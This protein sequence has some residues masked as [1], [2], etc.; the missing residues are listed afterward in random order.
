MGHRK[1]FDT[2]E[3]II[4][5]VETFQ[6]YDFYMYKERIMKAEH[7]WNLLWLKVPSIYM[8]GCYG[9]IEAKLDP[10][11]HFITPGQMYLS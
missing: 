8:Y 6:D 1:V 11:S 10:M 3:D 2:D 9:I 5:V 4:D 7:H